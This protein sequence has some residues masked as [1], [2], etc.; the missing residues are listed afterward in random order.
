VILIVSLTLACNQGAPEPPVTTGSKSLV[1]ATDEN[2]VLIRWFGRDAAG[3]E[4]DDETIL[5]GSAGAPTLKLERKTGENGS[6]A[7][8]ASGISRQ[9][10]DANEFAQISQSPWWDD[11]SEF[12]SSY[13]SVPKA[14][15]ALT[16]AFAYFDQNVLA[17]ELWASRHHELA[18]ILGMGYIDL[19]VNSTDEVGYRV[20]LEYPNGTETVLGE[21][22]PITVGVNEPISGSV[23]A[24][25]EAVDVLQVSPISNDLSN[26][27]DW[28]SDQG[29]RRWINERIFVGWQFSEDIVDVNGPETP[30]PSAF[31][32]VYRYPASN[33]FRATGA[34]IKINQNPILPGGSSDEWLYERFDDGSSNLIGF[35]RRDGTFTDAVGQPN[36]GLGL[37]TYDDSPDRSL[38]QDQIYCYFIKPVD[39]LGNEGVPQPQAENNGETNCTRFKDQIPPDPPSGLVATISGQTVRLAWNSVS[40]AV[41]YSIYDAET[42]PGTPMPSSPDSWN[43]LASV[44]PQVGQSRVVYEFNLPAIPDSDE[45]ETDLWFRV[46]AFDQAGNRSSLSQPVFAFVRDAKA[47][48]AALIVPSGQE[49]KSPDGQTIF[50]DN[51]CFQIEVDSDTD[52]VQIYRRIEGGEYE[53]IATL[54]LDD[55]DALQDW[56]DES[57]SGASGGFDVT[58]LIQAHDSDGNYSWSDPV[59]VQVGIVGE[60]EPPVITSIA[61]KQIQAGQINN[62][63]TWI[64]D[65]YPTF[66]RFDI[67]RFS[68]VVDADSIQSSL[69]QVTPSQSLIV[70]NMGS[71]I[72]DLGNGFWRATYTD[73]GLPEGAS[74][75]SY[76]VAAKDSSLDAS[77]F[78]NPVKAPS[79]YLDGIPYST[80]NIESAI[81]CQNLKFIDQYG[82]ELNWGLRA[83][84]DK[85]CL[86][87]ES[88][89]KTGIRDVRAH[90]VFRSRQ[91]ESGYVQLT[92]V[93]GQDEIF[94]ASAGFAGTGYRYVDEDASHGTYWYVVVILDAETGEP[95]HVT[96]PSKIVLQEL[97]KLDDSVLA[98][99]TCEQTQKVR[100]GDLVV[101][102]ELFFGDHRN[103][104][105]VC[106]WKNLTQSSAQTFKASG[107][108]FT[109]FVTDRG[110]S[111]TIAVKFD[112]I[113][114]KDS[115]TVIE[116][117][118]IGDHAP[119]VIQPEEGMKYRVE[120]IVFSSDP[121]KSATADVSIELPSGI[122]ISEQGVT[123]KIVLLPGA[124]ISTD[125]GFVASKTLPNGVPLEF[126]QPTT[127]PLQTQWV[128]DLPWYLVMDELPLAFATENMSFTPSKIVAQS[129]TIGHYFERF[130]GLGI[131]GPVYRTGSYAINA[132]DGFLQ[133]SAFQSD[134]FVITPDGIRSQLSSLT[135]TSYVASIPFGFKI[136]A[137]AVNFEIR[138]NQIVAGSLDNGTVASHYVHSS[139]ELLESQT[140]TG[141]FSSITLSESGMLRGH[142]QVADEVNWS[143]HGFVIRQDAFDNWTLIIAEI[144]SRHRP[145]VPPK[146]GFEFNKIDYPYDSAMTLWDPVSTDPWLVPGLNISDVGHIRWSCLDSELLADA[147]L[148]I[149]RSGVTHNFLSKIPPGG[150]SGGIYGYDT[151][152]SKANFGF[153]DSQMDYHDVGLSIYLPYPANFSF[154]GNVSS[155]D[156]NGCPNAIT[157]AAGYLELLADHWNLELRA[158]SANFED[159]VLS[160]GGGASLPHLF[161]D[162]GES[163][164]FTSTTINWA[165]NGRAGN[166]DVNQI[167][168]SN[169]E[170]LSLI[171][172][173]SLG[174]VLNNPFENPSVDP[175]LTI[176]ALPDCASQSDCP[177]VIS[178]RGNLISPYFGPLV[179]N[180]GG[181]VVQLVTYTDHQDTFESCFGCAEYISTNGINAEQVWI[182]EA[183]L[184]LKYPLL[185]SKNS[186]FGITLVGMDRLHVLPYEPAEW[187]EIIKL[188]TSAVINTSIS[189]ETGLVESRTSLFLGMTSLP[190]VAKAVID[191]QFEEIPETYDAETSNLLAVWLDGLI[192]EDSG[193]S[194]D[195]VDLYL[196]F[197]DIENLNACQSILSS[198]WSDGDWDYTT[199]RE[200]INASAEIEEG[201]FEVSFIE[202]Q[203]SDEVDNAVLLETLL[204]LGGGVGQALEFE[205]SDYET[206]FRYLRGDV[207][208]S[209]NNGG[210]GEDF[211]EFNLNFRF[212]IA[213]E[214]DVFINTPSLLIRYDKSGDFTIAGVNVSVDMFEYEVE[215]A[216]FTLTISTAQGNVGVN[217]GVTYYDGVEFEVVELGV[218]AGVFG[219]GQEVLYVGLMGDGQLKGDLG[220]Q[221][222]AG[223]LIGRVNQ[224]SALVLSNHGFADLVERVPLENAMTGIYLRGLGAVPIIND[225][226]ALS[227]DVGAELEVWYFTG[228]PEDVYGGTLRGFAYGE[229]LCVVSARGDVTL[230][231]AK[232]VH[233]GQA[234]TRFDGNAWVAGGIGFDCD[235]GTWGPTWDGRWWGDGWCWQAGAA[236]DVWWQSWDGWHYTMDADYE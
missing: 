159:G 3:L 192:S 35:D 98:N 231:I 21:T 155:F 197:E 187:L 68:P 188:D 40:D 58:Y 150:A 218:V 112:G 20:S 194:E 42:L 62:Q 19:D 81:W 184:E 180:D 234:A 178:Y 1:W 90:M 204:N 82:V 32:N 53:L 119:I 156:G 216:D 196:G 164:E 84:G 77:A 226:C 39:Y 65:Q 80:R 174:V 228:E 182:S 146:P 124:S 222:G 5:P 115:G 195:E 14:S 221:V 176:D 193:L 44:V 152:I 15:V 202:S 37:L 163:V 95:T 130:R 86:S 46:R 198:I 201:C 131:H 122:L 26:D 25:S 104:I 59:T 74:D 64:A 48:E 128:E 71:S 132:N 118:A 167:P 223:I 183:G 30:S 175:S 142:I 185:I 121:A 148:Y 106:E 172:D 55:F 160:I 108:G 67:Y 36:P 117:V 206:E 33:T 135:S 70:S 141:T 43:D 6:Y 235:P 78:S 52:F 224:S 76:I 9:S 66:D 181:Q 50:V 85:S 220:G 190:A 91:K 158:T 18:L 41:Q 127:D 114:A 162:G 186:G 57:I 208:F 133:S 116:G 209:S 31:F 207:V 28:L 125:L 109:Q 215:R 139:G 93:L 11:L 157:P 230:S 210:P 100:V 225:G 29:Q 56:C 138:S 94:Y 10:P 214:E 200:Q 63:I 38:P 12:L 54:A 22:S 23:I 227:L 45:D 236:A 7:E 105:Y 99:V 137:A 8:V 110:T 83:V 51:G 191:S 73:E 120:S 173:S 145:A 189:D 136:S 102:N 34:T 233:D 88:E 79:S 140:V 151:L 153:L 96:E 123:S 143:N 17:A 161:S 149:R 134:D 232:V 179:N 165:S 103:P 101:P 27:Q 92:P 61:P 2:S 170:G 203:V 171:F 47:P 75:Y 154:S 107:I 49:R 205:D 211:E 16:D 113:T 147:D 169:F 219:I 212:K 213:D 144:S 60:L 72:Q 217:G 111:I 97:S 166:V 168:Q 177:G 69:D 13:L 229:A 89:S 129:K 126:L 87:I 24:S 199:S 4:D